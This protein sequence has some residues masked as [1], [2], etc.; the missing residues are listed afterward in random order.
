MT[1]LQVSPWKVVTTGYLG[2][3]GSKRGKV[4]V[5]GQIESRCQYGQR[6]Q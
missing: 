5:T 3:N 2:V 6:G 4:Q 1:T